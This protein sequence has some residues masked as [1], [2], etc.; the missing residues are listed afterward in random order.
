MFDFLRLKKTTPEE[1]FWK[2]F[3]LNKTELEKFTNS[4]H[5][6]TLIYNRLTKA[7]K[8]Y[9]S[10]LFPE[11]TMSDDDQYVM[12]ITPD[13]HPDGIESTRK[14]FDS[15]PELENWVIKRFRQPTDTIHL[16]FNGVEYTSSDVE[17]L[18][19][20]NNQN[21]KINIKVFIRNMNKDEKNYQTLA[22]LYLDHI[23]GEYNTMTKIGFIDFHHLDEGKSV[24]GG[25]SV[26]ELRKLI[27]TEIYK[28]ST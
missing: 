9:N 11:L 28:V 16:N 13:G 8:K 2:W 3:E 10:I 21:D 12:I 23:L 14:L 20:V 1:K 15:K 6:N 5:S 26:L 25:I 17:I 24:E 22:F 27:E 18:P 4:D 7:M 19:Q